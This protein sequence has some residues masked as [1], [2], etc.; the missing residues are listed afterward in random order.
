MQPRPLPAVRSDGA[1]GPHVSGVVVVVVVVRNALFIQGTEAF[2]RGDK[3]AAS[4]LSARGA[5]PADDG[6]LYYMPVDVN[7]A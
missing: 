6:P 2:Q 4:T 5:P 3:A 7:V 1:C